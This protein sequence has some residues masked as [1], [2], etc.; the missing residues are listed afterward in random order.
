MNNTEFIKQEAEKKR[1]GLKYFDYAETPIKELIAKSLNYDPDKLFTDYDNHRDVLSVQDK[2]RNYSFYFTAN[3]KEFTFEIKEKTIKNSMVLKK[4]INKMFEAVT[5]VWPRVVMAMQDM[6]SHMDG[7]M[8]VPTYRDK[9]FS[10]ILF[11]KTFNNRNKLLSELKSAGKELDRVNENLYGQNIKAPSQEVL[12][13]KIDKL[14][15]LRD[16]LI[17]LK[18]KICEDLNKITDDMIEENRK[19]CV[20]VNKKF[21]DDGHMLYLC[22]EINKKN[23]TQE[24]IM[25][26]MPSFGLK[27]QDPEEPNYIDK[28]RAAVQKKEDERTNF[29]KNNNHNSNPQYKDDNN[30][31][32]EEVVDEVIEEIIEESDSASDDEIDVK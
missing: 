5:I 1:W 16:K 4:A 19:I 24:Q 9:T 26:R 29:E 28:L 20:K 25:D 18:A 7:V 27:Y 10:L 13:E 15:E 2:G 12:I 30:E 8:P 17:K 23:F 32:D 22:S 14:K 31:D 3:P 11:N 6:N 21:A